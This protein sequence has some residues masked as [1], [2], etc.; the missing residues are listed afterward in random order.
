MSFL[1]FISIFF[2]P[3]ALIFIHCSLSSLTVSCIL[4]GELKNKKFLND[5]SCFFFFNLSYLRKM[6][7]AI[8]LKFFITHYFNLCSIC[9]LSLVLSL[10]ISSLITI[11]V[12]YHHHHHHFLLSWY[13][14]FIKNL[15]VFPYLR[16]L[17]RKQVKEETRSE[18]EIKREW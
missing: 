2:Y 12:C 10:S 1:N 18:E 13:S 11:T 6:P 4:L 9:V 16:R 15:W 8:T 14:C 5:L 17:K 3:R 7:L